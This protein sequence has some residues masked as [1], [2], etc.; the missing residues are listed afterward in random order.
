[1]IAS[2]FL[3]HT[4]SDLRHFFP[5][6]SIERLKRI[7]RVTSNPNDDH[8]TPEQLLAVAPNAEYIITEWATG[9]DAKYFEKN[10]SLI[11][12]CRVGVEILNI[13][14]SAATANGVLVINLPGVHQTSVIELTL[15]YMIM[16]ARKVPTF[17]Q[18]LRD[19]RIA[20]AYNVALGL[21]HDLPSPGFDIHGSTIGLVGLGFIGTGLAKIL[22]FM[23]ANVIAYD[24]YATYVPEGVDLVPLDELLERSDIV[25]LHAKLT[26][27]TRHIIGARELGIMRRH[28]YVINTARGELV[29]NKALAEA[30]HN[31]TIA[32]AAVD[33]F[34]TEPQI[35]GH[36]LL[37]APNC[38]ATPHMTGNTPRTMKAL[39]DGAVLA[40]ERLCKD[41]QPG[42]IVN[43]EVL[44][45]PNLRW[46]KRGSGV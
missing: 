36:P 40:I 19:G 8:L 29:D 46:R 6:S 30:L 42:G 41:E 37:T 5:Q 31:G 2:V 14:I 13:D 12:I 23:G 15:T 27:E 28:A 10:T 4:P 38:I 11:A 9:A 7:A 33:V 34:D 1:M 45:R 22:L 16:S 21:G 35:Q 18:Q 44:E 25:S 24:P 20:I 3:T 32:G 17:E 26:P 39:A 43:F